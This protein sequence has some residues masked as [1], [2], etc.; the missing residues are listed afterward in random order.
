M[1][2]YRTDI[3]GL[4]AFAVIPVVLFHAGYSVLSG[5]YVGVDIFFVISGFLITSIIQREIGNNTFSL[6]RFYERRIRRIYPAALAVALA[7]IVAAGLLIPDGQFKKIGMSLIFMNLYSTNILFFHRAGYFDTSSTLNPFLHT[8]S[9]S[10]EE[11][12]YLI[13]PLFLLFATRLFKRRVIHCLLGATIFSF[14]A[15]VYVTYKWPDSAFYLIPFR[16]WELALGALLAVG[17]HALKLQRH[18]AE[19]L[20]VLGLSFILISIFSFTENTVFPGFAALLPCMGAALLIQAGNVP[21]N[22]VNEF[23]GNP[24]LRYFGLISYSLYLWH[25][26]VFVL[27]RFLFPAGLNIGGQIIQVVIAGV[28][29]HFSW[30]FIEAPFREK[31]IFVER[32]SLFTFFGTTTAATFV[33]GAIIVFGQ[34]L[35]M[36]MPETSLRYEQAELD[37]NPDRKTC[38]SDD[39]KNMRP[40]QFCLYGDKNIEPTFA[41]WG[42]SHGAEITPAIGSVLQQTQQSIKMFTYSQCP[43]ALG[44]STFT[45]HGCIAHNDNVLA[46]LQQHR[47]ID[48]VFMIANY[49]VYETDDYHEKFESGFKRTIAELKA[50]GKKVAV[51]YPI[52]GA[53]YSIPMMA[54]ALAMRGASID[55]LAIPLDH[56]AEIN[57]RALAMLDSQVDVARLHPEAV[58]CA[59]ENCRVAV[60]DRLLYFDSNHLNMFGARYVA[61]QL[62]DDILP[63]VSTHAVTSIAPRLATLTQSNAH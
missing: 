39:G 26:P 21:G 10:V 16:A 24:V 40:E 31:T 7:T 47:E 11:Q 49:N 8:W 58:L 5:G 1:D 57:A 37:N 62:R 48:T 17:G 45:R 46:Y 14:A 54:S 42:D 28:L 63:T 23:M 12:F 50:A 33:I 59:K 25:W 44:F 41:L 22:R 18:H 30:R 52:P 9:L 36:R 43:P 32:K 61:N 51:I 56:Y 55:L 13:F 35:K 38:H 15:C 4:R 20:S 6:V 60:N 53:R 2:R 34:G 29:A 3:D 27:A 19:W